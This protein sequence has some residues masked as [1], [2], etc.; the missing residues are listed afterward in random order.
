[1]PDAPTTPPPTTTTTTIPLAEKETGVLRGRGRGNLP[2]V[3]FVAD[4][5]TVGLFED[6]DVVMTAG[7]DTSLAPPG[8]P[9]G[10]VSNVVPRSSSAGPLLEIEPSVDLSRLYYVSV[11]LYQPG[12]EATSTTTGAP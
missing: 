2:Q 12:S 9:V 11:V 8:I 7:G 1:V 5:P 10:V 3:S 4:D 6:G